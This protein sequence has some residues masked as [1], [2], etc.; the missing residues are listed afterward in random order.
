MCLNFVHVPESDPFAMSQKSV[1]AHDYILIPI[2]N[3]F[4]G[5]LN[6]FNSDFP[7]QRVSNA[8]EKTDLFNF[9]G[10]C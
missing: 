5:K 8:L 1:N 2:P 6:I 4:F 7:S 3:I 10:A 9:V